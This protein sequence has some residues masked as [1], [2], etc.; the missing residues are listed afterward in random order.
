MG[1]GIPVNFTEAAELFQQAA[2]S[3]D[4]NGAHAFSTRT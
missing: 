2:D 3:D 4:A 1:I